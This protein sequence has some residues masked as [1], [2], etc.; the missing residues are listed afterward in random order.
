MESLGMLNQRWFPG[1]EGTG[2]MIPGRRS[3]GTEIGGAGMV[4]EVITGVEETF[5]VPGVV[6]D[7]IPTEVVVGDMTLL[8][9]EEILTGSMTSI[10]RRNLAAPLI[11]LGHC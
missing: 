1:K 3:C 6:V 8:A 11:D 7:I 2:V 10:T 5:A 4:T 9:E